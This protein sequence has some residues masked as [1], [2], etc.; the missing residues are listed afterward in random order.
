MEI[1]RFLDGKEV[2]VLRKTFFSAEARD[3]V[4]VF[5]DGEPVKYA[6]T[7]DLIKNEVWAAVYPFR[8][9]RGQVDMQLISG[10]VTVEYL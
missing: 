9:T 6:V 5:V 1:L 10:H 2:P 4:Q 3:K 7:A 8:L